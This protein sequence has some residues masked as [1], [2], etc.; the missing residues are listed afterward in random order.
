MP[1]IID[2]ITIESAFGQQVGSVPVG[3]LLAQLKSVPEIAT[4]PGESTADPAFTTYR[5]YKIEG[6]SLCFR[7]NRLTH[8][9]IYFL[10]RDG[11]TAFSGS[12]YGIDFNT[13][14]VQ[15]AERFGSP[16]KCH[17]SSTDYELRPMFP[18]ALFHV[19]ELLIHAESG[20]LGTIA[21]LT[22]HTDFRLI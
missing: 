3:N 21:L 4:D 22:I 16:V 7:S 19:G 20:G 17:S 18:W 15:L 9:F 13:S 8:I 6:V 11:Y 14:I 2:E 1:K 10:P 5:N 12:V